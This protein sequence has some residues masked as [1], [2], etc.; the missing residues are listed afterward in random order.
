MELH[1]SKIAL[2]YVLASASL[3]FALVS[4]SC[5]YASDLVFI[6]SDHSVSGGQEEIQAAAGFYG[7]NLK[8]VIVTPGGDDLSIRRTVEEK[9][10][11]GVAIEANT[12][13]AISKR[14]LFRA[15][16]RRANSNI[17]L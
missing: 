6:R 2:H 12:L 3:I 14:S 8:V 17:P 9:E 4:P 5:C 15:L 10:T 1:L 16:N 13:A 11:V 7:L